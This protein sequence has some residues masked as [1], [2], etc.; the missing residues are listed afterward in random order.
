M[1]F[2]MIK[3]DIK[4]TTAEFHKRERKKK[5]KKKKKEGCVLCKETQYTE[6][7]WDVQ[8]ANGKLGP[9]RLAY[10]P[11]PYLSERGSMVR[12]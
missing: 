5:K 2:I 8:W 7:E 3:V 11:L 12:C 4:K 1:S 6:W 10:P 9:P